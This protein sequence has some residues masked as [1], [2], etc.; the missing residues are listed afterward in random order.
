MWYVPCY[1]SGSG[2]VWIHG[3][4]S[5]FSVVVNADVQ[6]SGMS[7]AT[8]QTGDS[9]LFP[10]GL[11]WNLGQSLNEARSRHREGFV[12]LTLPVQWSDR[13]KA[14]VCI[15]SVTGFLKKQIP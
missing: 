10:R 4:Y 11:A 14:V 13:S 7:S 1:A 6:G 5:T 8:R 2:F 9:G 3:R 12:R 15:T